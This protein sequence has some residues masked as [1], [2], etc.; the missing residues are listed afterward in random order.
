MFRGFVLVA[1]VIFALGFASRAYASGY[2][3]VD[4][5]SAMETVKD[6]A[7]AKAKLEKEF[8]DKQKMIQTREEEIKKLTADYQKKQLIMS[9]DKRAEEEQKIQKK[10]M[11]YREL[12]QQAEMQMQ[13]RQVDIT[14]PIID[15]MRV[16]IKDIAEK[17]KYDMVYEKNQSGVFYA[18]D[19]KDITAEVIKKY[20]EL[21]KGGKSKN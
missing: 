21:N 16:A 19:S 1:S 11:E 12:V 20:D 2:A 9:A 3:H 7:A 17:E 6:G 13:K 14:K 4:L 8:K 10:M 15:A 5:Q 18:K